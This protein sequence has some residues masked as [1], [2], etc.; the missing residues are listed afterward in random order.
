[1]SGDMAPMSKIVSFSWTTPALICG[2]KVCTRRDWNPNYA[3]TFHSGDELQAYDRSQRIGGKQIAMVRLVQPVHLE[4]LSEMSDA[5]YDREGFRFLLE[6]P[7]VWPKTID[8]TPSWAFI[9]SVCTWEGFESWR[10][11]GDSMYVVRFE[12][13]Q[14]TGYGQELKAKYEQAATTQV[15]LSD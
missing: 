15:G 13:L 9:R 1:M 5:D 6:H 11:S 7:E 2:V 8:Q 12:L 4:P 14:L 10:H 3:L